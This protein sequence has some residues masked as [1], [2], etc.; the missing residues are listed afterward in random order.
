MG[1]F[2]LEKA[3]GVGDGSL[4]IA[5]AAA[6]LACL[7]AG[8]AFRA[9]LAWVAVGATLVASCAV[10]VGAV[11]FDHRVAANVRPTFLPPDARWVDHAR[12]G[13]TTLIQTPATPTPARTSSSSGT[14]R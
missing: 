6:A 10:S 3:V 11:S 2:R 9:R 8:C 13:D 12:V 5:L 4:F 14:A 7:A 1:V